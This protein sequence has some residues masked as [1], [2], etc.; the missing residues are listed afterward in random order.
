MK[1]VILIY[2]FAFMAVT[3]NA[4]VTLSLSEYREQMLQ[5]NPELQQRKSTELGAIYNRRIVNSGNLPELSGSA[6]YSYNPDN[7]TDS[8]G[9]GASIEQNVY[10]GGSVRRS[11]QLADINI[12]ASEWSVISQQDQVKYLAEITYWEAV[13]NSDLCMVADYY[14]QIVND[15]LALV[16]K[17]YEQGAISRTDLLVVEQQQIAAMQRR[18]S[19]YEAMGVSM[20]QINHN[21]GALPD[22]ELTLSDTLPAPFVPIDFITDREVVERSPEYMQAVTQYEGAKLS[23]RLGNSAYLPSVRVGVSGHYSD[24]DFLPSAYAKLSIPIF[25]FMERKKVELK[26]R[27]EEQIAATQME[28]VEEQL[29]LALS[30]TMLKIRNLEE[31]WRFVNSSLDIASDNLRLNTLSY[32]EGKLPIVDVINAQASWLDSYTN[33]IVYNYNFMV[34]LSEYSRLLGGA[35]E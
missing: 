23:T 14:L 24:T 35:T 3:L 32:S 5:H 30:N 13:A 1:K 26:N 25:H 2:V 9:V 10:S 28:K 20:R 27:T 17:R 29:L 11:M 21:R 7:N 31:R 19:A 22:I 8:Y 33:V 34:V 16:N 12:D 6:E 4:Q 18:S 15:L